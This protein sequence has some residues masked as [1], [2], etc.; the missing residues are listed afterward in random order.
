V[1]INGAFLSY[2]PFQVAELMEP[3][4]VDRFHFTAYNID[5]ATNTMVDKCCVLMYAVCEPSNHL[6]DVFIINKVVISL[7]WPISS[8][9]AG[10]KVGDQEKAF[11]SSTVVPGQWKEGM[12]GK[13]IG[14]MS[15]LSWREV[16]LVPK[17]WL[18][19]CIG[20]LLV[21]FDADNSFLHLRWHIII[22][23]N[24][25]NVG[26]IWACPTQVQ[27]EQKVSII[28]TSHSYSLCLNGIH[29][30]L[31]LSLQ[32]R[33]VYLIL[34]DKVFEISHH[35]QQSPLPTL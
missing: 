14:C 18:S 9:N 35:S 21:F 19:R 15:L 13:W 31:Y 1:Y 16:K 34:I 2:K 4:K 5:K 27:H 11:G 6:L 24:C 32:K 25:D 3:K 12:E 8:S 10:A 28:G 26:V 22:I 29:K 20:Y 17:A 33:T 23:G 7:A 30:P